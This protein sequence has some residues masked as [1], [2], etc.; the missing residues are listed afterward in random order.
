MG[1][2]RQL[3]NPS[4]FRCRVS[5]VPTFEATE[6]SRV[7]RY[8]KLKRRSPRE[9]LGY[10]KL[11]QLQAWVFEGEL[12]EAS[13]VPWALKAEVTASPRVLRALEAEM[14]E[15]SRVPR[16][17]EAETTQSLR[18]PCPSIYE[19]G[20]PGGVSGYLRAWYR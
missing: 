14:T 15:S 2:S 1:L 12:T 5:R 17:L 16:A 13:R 20:R 7:P 6:S 10:P 11:T 9:S 3:A 18:V 19:T 8:R 4:H